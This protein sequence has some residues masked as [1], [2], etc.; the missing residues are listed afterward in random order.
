MLRVLAFLATITMV[1]D[2]LLGGTPVQNSV[3]ILVGSHGHA[4]FIE[5]AA[6]Q[7]LSTMNLAVLG[8]LM[9]LDEGFNAQP[10]LLQAAHYDYGR[11]VYILRLRDNLVFHNGRKATSADLEFSLVRG[12]FSPNHSFY[13]TYIGNIEGID[14][15]VG[16]KYK[17]G[18]VSGVK[19]LDGLTIEVKLRAPNPAFLPSLIN[20][21]F[22]IVP[23]E[24]FTDNYLTW[25]TYPIGAGPYR[26]LEPG[27]HNGL[28][29]L[30]KV[31]PA[32]PGP[33]LVTVYTKNV[34]PHYDISLLAKEN[35]EN[36]ETHYPEL[37][38][39][40]ATLFLSRLNPLSSDPHFRKALS[41]LIDR[42]RFVVGM[43]GSSSATQMLPQHFW[44]RD[45]IPQTYNLEA[46]RREVSLI[47]KE[48][49]KKHWHFAIFMGGNKTAAGEHIKSELTAQLAAAGLDFSATSTTEKFTSKAAATALPI[50]IASRIT[51]YVDPLIMLQSFRSN[52]PDPYLTAEHDPEFE[53]L[54]E[55]AAQAK[56]KDDRVVTVR[57]LSR[58][59]VD[60]IF[61]VPLVE[62]RYPIFYNRRNVKLGNQTL[63]NTLDIQS[64]EIL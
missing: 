11:G 62:R 39:A 1:P 38:G 22:S 53:R 26:V 4:P 52:G 9:V 21:Y 19:V 59:L 20:P 36:S 31:N 40:I 10:S 57:R 56:N 25:K 45:T 63:P 34:L 33:E 12:F 29:K 2:Q 28:V 48:L 64:L 60:N 50:V 47:P 14:A 18:V 23:Q 46:A 43:P 5:T 51:D 61:C 37:T 27:F 49:V 42:S 16:Q 15:A 55:A 30:S 6:A 3:T 17:S 8:R 35:A 32:T 54:F 58:Y 24:A 44:G 41:L 7:E 13:R